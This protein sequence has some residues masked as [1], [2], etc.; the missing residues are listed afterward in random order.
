MTRMSMMGCLL[1]VGIAGCG[2][3]PERRSGWIQPVEAVQAA[4]D[5]PVFGIRGRFALTVR[6]I[7]TQDDRT[8]L[9]SERDYR[10]Q[11]NLTIAMPTTVADQVAARLQLPLADL[12]NRRLLVDGQARR[13]RIA[14]VESDGRR[15]GGYY[16]QT[17][18]TVRDPAQIMFAD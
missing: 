14:F 9:N 4:N 10:H 7:G 6:A 13:V 12:R 5:D 1:A 18:V 2:S 16:Y 11:T 8:Y 3:V 15:S 17:H